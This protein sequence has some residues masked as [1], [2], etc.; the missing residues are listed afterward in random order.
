MPTLDGKTC[1]ITGATSGIGLATA[2]R[3]APLGARLLLVGRDPAKGEAARA[4]L[5]A[6]APSAEVAFFYADL[7]TLGGVRRLATELLAAAPRIDVLLNNAGA[8]FNARRETADGL[9]RTFALNHMAYFLLSRL[10]LERIVAS[11]PAR[12]VNVASA[13]HL[14]AQLD[15]DDLQTKRD[16]SGWKAYRRSKLCNI[17]F[18]RALACRLAGT[19]V[20]ANALHPGFVAS[21]F[22]DNNAGLFRLGFSFAK[23]VAAIS[24]EKGAETPAYLAASPEVEGETGLYFAKCRPATPSAAAQDDAAAERLWQES[25]RLAGIPA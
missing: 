10:L 3:L 5:R 2:E 15:L 20:T 14:G 12:I 1:I 11:A 9:E 13:A 25:A 21:R 16:Y 18:T 6:L 4:R 8:I 17:L 24:A 7:A 22:G 23:R 19:G